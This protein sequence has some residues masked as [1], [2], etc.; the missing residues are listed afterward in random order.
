MTICILGRQPA[1]GLAELESLYGSEKLKR[2]GD[3]VA[4]VDAE[5]EFTRL[6]GTVKAAQHLTTVDTANPAK[7]FNHARKI[8]PQLLSDVP[9]GKLKL[10]VSLHGLTLP[11]PKLN[12]HVLSLK[13]VAKKA[14]RSVRAVPNKSSALSSAQTLHN[15]LTSPL[16]IELVFV[17]DGTKTH[18]GQ[19][20]DVQDIDAYRRRDQER[21]RRDT[22]VGMLPPKLAQIIINLA[23]GT[24]TSGTILDPFC[25][26]GVLL[27]E[28]SL[29]GYGVYG[30][31]IE[32]KMVRYSRDNLNW[33]FERYQSD[34]AVYYE[35]ADATEHI[36]RQPVEIIACEGYLGHPFANQP[37]QEALKET[38]QT[39]NTIMK[40]F[41]KN[42]A[43]QLQPGTRLC[44]AAPAWY[45]RG[46]VY[47]LPS[48]DDLEGMGYNRIDF[49]HAN[50]EDLIYHRQDQVTG[51]E[52]VVLTKE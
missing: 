45:A 3:T 14:G 22:Y 32:E 46:K 24:K 42:I 6:G 13:T 26:T 27:Q 33:L 36:W 35:I 28:A 7:V 37:S 47:R 20:S 19:V 2:F 11:L 43:P 38:I 8:F 39:S 44:I 21:P 16:G 41:L 34:T 4:L 30:T 48:L 10:G 50:R 29:M 1:L 9:P 12:A 5:V 15:Q 23:T 17:T 18:I 49:V 52:L 31:D 40:K 51:R 25:G